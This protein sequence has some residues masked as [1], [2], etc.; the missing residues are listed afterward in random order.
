MYGVFLLGLLLAGCGKELSP[1]DVPVP[2]SQ[3]N[4]AEA[5]MPAGQADSGQA[6]PGQAGLGQADSG[7]TAPGQAALGQAAPAQAG[8]PQAASTQSVRTDK[9]RYGVY[10]DKNG[11]TLALMADGTGSKKNFYIDLNGSRLF[12]SQ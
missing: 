8:T 3:T 11:R 2:P 7:Q 9:L 10:Q 4:Q 6:A 12:D 1:A 5:A